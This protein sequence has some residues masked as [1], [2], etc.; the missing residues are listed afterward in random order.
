MIRM[1]S[2]FLINSTVLKFLKKQLKVF[3]YG[4]QQK[5]RR[6]ELEY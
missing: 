2:E 4:F 5:I 1:L 3:G 6:F